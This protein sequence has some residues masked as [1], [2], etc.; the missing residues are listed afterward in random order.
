[1]LGF[2]LC[3]ILTGCKGTISADVEI[4]YGNSTKYS[5]LELEEAAKTVKQNF[6]RSFEDCT[7]ERLVY[8]GDKRSKEHGAYY[9][10]ADTILFLMDYKTG[11]FSSASL[12]KNSE[13]PEWQVMLVRDKAGVWKVFDAGCGYG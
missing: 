6:I 12:S 4:D 8:A 10:D 1:M 9:T 2:L 7:M 3:V 11:N 13:Y 5:R